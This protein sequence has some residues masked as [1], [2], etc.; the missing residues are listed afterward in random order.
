M[1]LA[2]SIDLRDQFLQEHGFHVLSLCLQQTQSTQSTQM[3]QQ[4]QHSGAAATSTAAL[5][6]DVPLVD[7]CVDLVL[8][9][10]SDALQVSVLPCHRVS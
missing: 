6:L 1:L 3:Q 5:C 7:A 9:L 2:R 4:Q 10:G 8:S